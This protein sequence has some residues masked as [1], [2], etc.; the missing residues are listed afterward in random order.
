MDSDANVNFVGD[1][2]TFLPENGSSSP[3]PRSATF[4]RFPKQRAVLISAYYYDAYTDRNGIA[5]RALL[6]SVAADCCYASADK[7][8]II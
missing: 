7:Y 3:E 6:L 8:N 4:Q 5:Y 2:F 1:R